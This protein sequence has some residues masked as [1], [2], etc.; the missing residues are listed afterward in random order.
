MAWSRPSG[1]DLKDA[2]GGYVEMAARSQWRFDLSR[3]M[4]TMLDFWDVYYHWQEGAGR[5]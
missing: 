3:V 1:Y 5:V 4:P 2:H